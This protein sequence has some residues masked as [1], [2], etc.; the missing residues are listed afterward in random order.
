[1]EAR[2]YCHSHAAHRWTF[3]AKGLESHPSPFTTS[4]LPPVIYFFHKSSPG[5]TR[6]LTNGSQPIIL[7]WVPA[8]VLPCVPVATAR[9]GVFR[10][11]R[12]YLECVSVWREQRH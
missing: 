7:R 11:A 10:A 9:A 6:A 4:Y 5:R 2:R 12:S 8:L 3:N 1:M